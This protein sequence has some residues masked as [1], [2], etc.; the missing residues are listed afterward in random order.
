MVINFVG[1]IFIYFRLYYL[2]LF[3]FY[4]NCYLEN[5]NLVLP[6]ATNFLF[7]MKNAFILSLILLS[8]AFGEEAEYEDKEKRRITT[9]S[10]RVDIHITFVGWVLLLPFW[11]V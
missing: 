8:K 10:V 11:F 4:Y 2:H 7:K 5:F 6:L 9:G 3:T 1:Y